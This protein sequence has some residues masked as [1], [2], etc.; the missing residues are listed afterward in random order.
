[1]LKQTRDAFAECQKSIVGELNVMI[2]EL[3]AGRNEEVYIRLVNLRDELV[4]DLLINSDNQFEDVLEHSCRKYLEKTYEKELN[5][6]AT[7]DNV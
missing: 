1:M 5:N 7:N 2:D 4:G 6:N 3:I